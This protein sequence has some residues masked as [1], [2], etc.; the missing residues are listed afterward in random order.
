LFFEEGIPRYTRMNTD[1]PGKASAY[2]KLGVSTISPQP[3][4]WC[5][6]SLC[7]CSPGI[8]EDRY[9]PVALY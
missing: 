4:Q 1:N 3:C 5:I 6:F 2:Q 7:S 9:P 8:A